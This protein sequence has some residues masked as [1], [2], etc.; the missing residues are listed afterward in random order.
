MRVEEPC[1]GCRP[2]G[3]PV[4]VVH[5]EDMR[6]LGNP[7]AAMQTDSTVAGDT[8]FGPSSGGML[9]VGD[10]FACVSGRGGSLR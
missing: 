10:P 2:V 4:V 5:Q 3:L 8:C 1:V 7:A 6:T 9:G